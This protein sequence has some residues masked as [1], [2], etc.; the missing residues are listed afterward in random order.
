M[1]PLLQVPRRV[2]VVPPDSRFF[3]VQRVAAPGAVPGREDGGSKVACGME[4][5]YS[6]TF[7]PE[8]SDDYGC[9]LVVCTEREKFVVPVLARGAQAA[10][11]LPDVV[12]FGQA[13]TKLAA[14]QV[15]LVRNVGARGAHY[16]LRTHEPF[17][18][19]PAAGFLGPGEMVQ[20]HLGFTPPAA[21]PY[22]GEL[23]LQ[24][25]TVGAEG[26]G[27]VGQPRVAYTTLSGIARDVMEVGLSQ[28]VVSLVPTYVTKTSQKTFR[29]VNPTDQPVAF[30]VKAHAN[31]AD[32]MAATAGR[33]ATLEGDA[34]ASLAEAEAEE[35]RR[36]ARSAGSRAHVL[37]QPGGSSGDEGGSSGLGPG[38]A[39]DGGESE[40]EDTILASKRASVGRHYKS[41]RR[42]TVLDRHLFGDKNFVVSPA[43]GVVLPR[44]EM[45]VTVQ[46]GTGCEGDGVEGIWGV[47][48]VG[49]LG[50]R[51]RG[52]G[53]R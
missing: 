6:V 33:L 21:G 48:G 16:T 17:S 29:I 18:V 34:E 14:Q 47:E 25:S 13:G 37:P 20:V 4:V 45:E 49:K 1:H 27:P 7:R 28:P 26:A 31:A 38:L 32:E 9:E 8:T 12:D 46:V 43:E 42:D 19:S 15:V 3:S 5:V 24:Y 10:L 52:W 36:R 35:A 23:E 53:R 11:D 30:A 40:D 51:C 50:R 2:K 44:S 22:Q 39:G 41:L